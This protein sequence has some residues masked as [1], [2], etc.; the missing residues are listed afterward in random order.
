M[1]IKGDDGVFSETIDQ[2]YVGAVRL[3]WVHPGGKGEMQLWRPD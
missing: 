3:P 2:S 1:E